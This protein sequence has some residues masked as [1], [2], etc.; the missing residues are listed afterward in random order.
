MGGAAAPVTG[1]VLRTADDRFR[2]LPGWSFPARYLEAVPGF[3]A[4]GPVR[5]HY[6]DEGEAGASESLT[7]LLLHGHPTWGYLYRYVIP[8]IVRQG[9]RAVVP[10]LPGFGRSDK[11]RDPEAYTFA[12][13]RASLIALIEQLD[14]RAIVLVVH[15]WG[16]TLGMT[17]PCEMPERFAGLVCFNTWLATGA[18]P[19]PV[20][21]RNWLATARAE[22][23][24]NVRSL[25]ART[26]RI[27]TLA[28]CNAYQAPFPDAAHK[29]AL[30]ALPRIFP[31]A[32]KD[33]GTK[34]ARTAETWWSDSFDGFA[35]LL[36]GMRDPILPPDTMRGL[37]GRIRGLGAPVAIGNA[38]HFVPEWGAEFAPDL[39]TE[40]TALRRRQMAGNPAGGAAA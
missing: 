39:V 21:Y 6:V 27:L 23:D 28:Q 13:L 35:M 29:A 24:L 11:P 32:P 25:M 40:V 20:G 37:A 1:A 10:D 4:C 17:I 18:R 14:L 19:L 22:T 3:D 33:P 38:G 12:G 2:E 8:E 9:H 26:N 36:A 31:A 5:M 16:G 15:E 7:F 30:V 34:L